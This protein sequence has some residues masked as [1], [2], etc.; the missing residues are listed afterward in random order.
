MII[1]DY[2]AGRPPASIRVPATFQLYEPGTNGL[3]TF[4]NQPTFIARG[5][6][7]ARGSSTEGLSK[8]SLRVEFHDE[9]GNDRDQSIL[10]MPGDG[11]WVMYAP[12]YFEPVL[13]HNPFMHQLSRDIGRYSPRTRFVEVY[14]VTSGTGAITQDSYN[15]IYVLMERIE[16]GGDRVD[17]GRLDPEDLQP[18]AVTGGYVMKIDRLDPGDGGL[19]AGG[20]TI[21]LVDPSEE[22]LE[23]PQRAAQLNYL[24]G[25]MN[26]FG[27]ALDGPA[28][29][30]PVRGYRPFIDVGSWIDHHLMNVL[31]FN[32]DALRLSAYFYKERNGPIA[33]G[34]LW[35]FDRAL[36]SNDGRDSNPRVWRSESGDRGTDFFNYPWWGR[37]FT[38]LEFFQEYI[39]RYQALRRREFS[40]TNLWALTDRLANQVRSAQPREVSR[41]GI[42]PRGGTYQAEVNLMKVWLRDRTEFMDSQFVRPP[43]LAVPLGPVT[44]GYRVQTTGALGTTVYVTTDGTDPRVSGGGN[45]TIRTNTRVIARAHNPSHTARTGADNP[46]LVSQWS[47]AVAATFVTQPT[48]LLLTEIMYHP[49]EG[50][51]EA[52]DADDFEFLELLNTGSAPVA[53]DGI[54]LRGGVDLLITPTNAPVPLA[55][56]TRGLLVRD[57]AR[58]LER[59]PGATNILGEFRGQLANDGERVA[60]TGLIEESVFDFRYDPAWA[61]VTDGGGFS[62]VLVDERATQPWLLGD[63]RAWKASARPGGSP[64][65][66][67]PS[68]QPLAPVLSATRLPNGTVRLSFVAEAGVGYSLVARDRLDTGSWTV[69]E[70]FPAGAS[71]TVE[72]N[73]TPAGAGRFYQVVVL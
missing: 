20:L 46:P 10:G 25:H 57:R 45:I 61:P 56:G 63:A 1:H 11:D 50:A 47:G 62:L 18:P 39:D 73:E 72:R 65:L 67:E 70:T 3:T 7:G 19:N 66:P 55:A 48:P 30:D 9:F 16:S 53:L 35:D 44:N 40:T 37:M 8:V 33:F 69:V 23:Q 31:A 6:V 14:L 26:Q 58:F 24:R 54:R 4:T 52:G 38:D 15:G 59:Y 17:A 71:R 51:T 22:E 28:Y 32:V 2:D 42:Q 64:G 41:W 60:L 29:T 36:G 5:E 12:N 27:A 43:T 49:A 13:I 21:A 34:P 68:A